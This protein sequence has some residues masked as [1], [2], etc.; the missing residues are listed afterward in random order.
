MTG[1]Y[2][3]G[4]GNPSAK[5]MVVGEAPGAHEEEQGLPFVGPA[6]A[7][8]DECLEKG[9]TSRGEV[10][11]TNVVK[12]RP[13][14]NEIHRLKELGHSI[15]DFEE[16][17][18][19]EIKE[20]NPNCI[21]AFGNTALKALTGEVGIQKFRG[22]ILPN[23]RG[24]T[25]KV[26]ASIHPA[27]IFHTQDGSMRSYRDKAFIEFDVARAVQQ[28]SFREY[29]PP[30]RNLIIA[31]NSLDLYRFIDR[32]TS[33]G[34]R[35]IAYD[36]ETFKATP[37][38]ISFAFSRHEA[39]SVPLFNLAS[40]KNK[41][42]WHSNDLAYAWQIIAGLLLDP[43]YKL[44]GHNL[45]FD[46]G[47]LE[48]IGLPTCWPYFDT[49]LAFHVMYPELPKKLFFVSSILT[50]EPYY[51]DELE[52][53]NPK[54]EKLDKRLLYNA[55][56]SAVE[57]EVYEREVEELTEMG[58]LDWYFE[59]QHPKHK[60]YYNMERN[61]FSRDATQ[62]KRLIKKYDR[63]TKL[64]HNQNTKD[65]GYELNVM[66]NGPKGQVAATIFGN[67]RCP[68]RK[69]TAEETLEMLMLNAV[70][71]ERRK[72]ILRNIL[73][74]RKARKT[75][76]TYVKAKVS[77]IDS[78]FHTTYNITGTETN[79]TSTS[80]PKAPV[81]AEPEG[82]AFQT[83]TK[84]GDVGADLRV[85]FIPSPSKVLLEADLSACQARIVAHLSHDDDAIAL[86]NRKD[87]KK[88]KF[89]IKDDIHTWTAI[90]VTALMFEDIDDEIRQ[91]GKKTRHAGNFGMGK[92]RLSMMAQISEWR[93]GRC[94]E[95]FHEAN[96]KIS[97]VY[98][99]EVQQALADN[100]MKL[101]APSGSVRMFFERWGEEMFKEAY[102][103]LPQVIEA[104]HRA[105]AGFRVAA[106]AP[107]IDFLVEAHD[108]FTVEVPGDDK[109]IC[110]A[111]RIFKEELEVPIDFSKCSLPRGELVIPCDIQIGRKN[112]K[113]MVKLS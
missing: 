102:A 8:V 76:G 11:V 107:W 17:L 40:A 70:K 82:L 3:P 108:S 44:I 79:R 52:E 55:K 72:R 32:H 12:I 45:K 54:K 113:E 66:S 73:K 18:W 84:H 87:F 103:H 14:N 95:R 64:I 77:P 65:L 16:E 27:S 75:T 37:M 105:D 86:M 26:V 59:H 2:V 7:I 111:A 9:G 50:E 21:L 47:R 43:Q 89:G 25:P 61:G 19:R 58:L 94:L 20:I 56:D 104:D 93:A 98:W 36:I 80:K 99:V 71:D 22:S 74:E 34:K 6:G 28:S 91:L 4:N 1:R 110:E 97:Q 23:K 46:Q 67:L 62:Q 24:I 42:G 51:K 33:A 96:P 48:E 83:L 15:E 57:F 38:C 13:P 85:M 49:Q 39:I 5:L 109:H 10:Y 69:D 101:V 60:F 106:R 30:R 88:N 68:M 100:N 53:Y 41:D 112:W 78:K 31:R 81:V 35:H 29:K 90:L 92:R 63:Y